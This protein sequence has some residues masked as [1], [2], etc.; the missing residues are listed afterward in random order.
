MFVNA[1]DTY[2]YLDSDGAVLTGGESPPE[3]A[4]TLLLAPGGSIDDADAEMYGIKGQLANSGDV[5]FRHAVTGEA[6]V[7][8]GGRAYA[9]RSQPAPYKPGDRRRL[10][11]HVGRALK[12]EGKGD[13]ENDDDESDDG[14]GLLPDTA[15]AKH[16]KGPAETK[17]QVGPTSAAGATTGNLTNPPAGPKPE[18]KGDK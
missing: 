6:I 18:T 9:A 4:A 1:T 17:H 14:S 15:R 2:F 3:R 8:R 5:K 16:V 11:G 10:S 12:I 13:G 7:H